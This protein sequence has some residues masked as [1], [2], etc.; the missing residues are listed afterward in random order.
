MSELA[1]FAVVVSWSLRYFLY[2]QGEANEK[3]NCY[4]KGNFITELQTGV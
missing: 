4:Y 1:T 2:P 3:T